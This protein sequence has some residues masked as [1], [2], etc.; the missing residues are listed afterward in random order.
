M[1][2]RDMF[3]SLSIV[4]IQ[5]KSI[6]KRYFGRVYLCMNSFFLNQESYKTWLFWKDFASNAFK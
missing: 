1:I 4:D 5:I 6:H 2:T 3:N